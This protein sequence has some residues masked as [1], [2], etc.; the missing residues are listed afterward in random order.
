MTERLAHFMFLRQAV[1]Y[2]AT[3]S[4]VTEIWECEPGVRDFWREEAASVLM[5]LGFCESPPDD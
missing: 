5:F 1:S 3:G 4:E 2:G